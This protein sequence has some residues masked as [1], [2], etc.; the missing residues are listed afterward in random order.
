MKNSGITRRIDDLGRVVIP[1]EL[2][3]DMKINVHDQLKIFVNDDMICLKKADK[4]TDYLDNIEQ[5]KVD[6]GNKSIPN[7]DDVLSKLDD[8][9]Q[10]IKEY[11]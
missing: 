5:M 4:A 8:I 10:A 3:R 2:R 7:L 1:I 9:S 11:C 6:F